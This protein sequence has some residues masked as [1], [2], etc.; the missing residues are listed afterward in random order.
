MM[1]IIIIFLENAIAQSNAHDNYDEYAQFDREWSVAPKFI[2][3][4]HLPR[5]M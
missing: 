4:V 3:F 5:D 2:Q 1:L